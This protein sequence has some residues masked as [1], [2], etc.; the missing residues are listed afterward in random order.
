[1]AK[2]GAGTNDPEGEEARV[3]QGA[4][5]DFESFSRI[6]GWELDFR[7]LGAAQLSIPVRARSIGAVTVT[8]IGI[9][10]SYHQRGMPP[11]GRLTFGLPHSGIRNWFHSP[12]EH[13]GLMNFNHPSGFDCVSGPGFSATTLSLDIGCVVKTADA[14]K[15]PLPGDLVSPT[16]ST[17]YSRSMASLRLADSVQ[18]ILADN[19]P[20]SVGDIEDD[21]VGLLIDIALSGRGETYADAGNPRSRV[22][23]KVLDYLQDHSHDP[24]RVRDICESTGIPIRTLDRAFKEHFGVSPKSYIKQRQLSGV[25]SDLVSRTAGCR[26][27]DVA[28][29]WG[30]WHMGQFA[31]DYRKLFGELPSATIRNPAG[32][33]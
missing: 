20:L 23:I 19:G 18:A 21:L 6:S 14:L 17:C 25:R 12:V 33:H 7:Q 2:S 22:I 30:F 4:F 11:A 16:V 3:F 15:L 24:V 8:D 1:M 31:R 9:N 10:C 29:K 5:A 26:I 32:T 28:N 13:A 27:S